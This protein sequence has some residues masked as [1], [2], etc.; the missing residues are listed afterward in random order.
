MELENESP[1]WK[2]IKETL[3]ER[4]RADFFKTWIERLRKSATIEI[5]KE[6][7]SRYQ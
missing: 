1:V 5:N 6:T 3:I 4:K 2:K 7:L